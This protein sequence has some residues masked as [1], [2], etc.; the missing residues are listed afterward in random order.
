MYYYCVVNLFCIEVNCELSVSGPTPLTGFTIIKVYLKFWTFTC[1][2]IYFFLICSFLTQLE[3]RV[4]SDVLQ[5]TLCDIII[6]NCP[7]FRKVYVPYLTNQSYQ[8]KTYQRLMWVYGPTWIVHF[9]L[10]IS[11]C[12]AYCYSLVSLRDENHEFR[13]VVEKLE[14]NPV[15]QRLPL[16]SFLI[17]PFQRITRLKLLVQVPPSHVEI[18][19]PPFS[20]Y[21]LYLWR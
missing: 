18:C 6:K 17:L 14:R 4:E 3:E 5:F 20:Y 10:F 15:C 12:I 8:D 19:L 1:P 21:L 16:R 9:L 7:R 11:V 2:L 13:R